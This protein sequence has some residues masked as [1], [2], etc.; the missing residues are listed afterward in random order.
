M[1]N[2][3]LFQSLTPELIPPPNAVREALARNLRENRILR[4]LLRVSVRAVEER[5]YCEQVDVSLR[6]AERQEATK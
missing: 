4:A 6:A 3:D 5:I 1:N 2:G